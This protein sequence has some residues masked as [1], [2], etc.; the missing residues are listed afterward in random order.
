MG[1]PAQVTRKHFRFPA[2]DDQVGVKLAT[3][4]RR[5]LFQNEPLLNERGNL[6]GNG[7]QEFEPTMMNKNVPTNTATAAPKKPAAV[8]Q[9][10]VHTKAQQEELKKHKLNLPDYST[11]HSRVIEPQ[12]KPNLFG[13]MHKQSK[14]T[15]EA[16]SFGKRTTG[17][18]IT[19][20]NDSKKMESS[21]FV[22]TYV[23][24]SVIPDEVPELTEISDQELLAAMKK[25]STSYLILDNEDTLFREKKTDDPA[26]QK[27]NVPNEE[28]DIPVTR[29]QYQKIRPNMQRFG[30][31]DTEQDLPRS[32][33]ELK[34]AKNQTSYAQKVSEAESQQKKG[35]MDKSLSGIIEESSFEMDN[36]KYFN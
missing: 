27:F 24:A 9:K 12:K 20:F 32:R 14:E 34:S 5:Q 36:S 7:Y 6:T 15:F 23:P 3:G 4:S 28:P 25:D 26:V 33:T 30:G 35:I 19:N 18:K 2:Y 22:P 21:Y 31:T 13:N 11:N 16:S 10:Q 17:R 29:R 1:N 8:D